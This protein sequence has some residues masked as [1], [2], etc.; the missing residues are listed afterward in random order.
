MLTL[1]HREAKP[2]TH[3][4]NILI[5]NGYPLGYFRD[6]ISSMASQI[7]F[8]KF[9]WCT[10]LVTENMHEKIDILAS[11]NIAYFF[12]G[13]LFEKFLYQNKLNEYKAFLREYGCDYMEISNGTIALSNT[14]KCAYISEFSKEFKV[15]SEVGLKNA[16]KSEEMPPKKWIEYISEDIEAGAIKV[17]TESRESGTSGICRSN[18]DLRV[19]LLEEI[20]DSQLDINDIIFEAPNKKLQ[21]YFIKKLG[22]NCNLG[23]I[24]FS[25]IIGLETLRLG[26]RSDTFF[27]FE[28]KGGKN[29]RR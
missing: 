9:G 14:E 2:R 3:G 4:L 16:Q 6:V 17:I 26:L 27:T 7:D 24:A 19:G 13:T 12:G 22:S 11:H 15:F 29:E 8:V 28:Q 21:I 20:L 5:D 23:N 10:A 18:G 25:D 1:P